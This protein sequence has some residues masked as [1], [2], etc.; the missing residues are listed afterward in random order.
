MSNLILF[1]LPFIL[2][3]S[4][5]LKVLKSF[6]L[7][8]LKLYCLLNEKVQNNIWRLLNPNYKPKQETCLIADP[9]HKVMLGK[10]FR[11]GLGVRC[12]KKNTH[13]KKL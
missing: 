7:V 6:S 9:W 8:F 2:S 13:E 3:L 12:L 5:K 10:T 4:L 11:S 1:I